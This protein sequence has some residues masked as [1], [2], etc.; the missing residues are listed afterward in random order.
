MDVEVPSELRQSGIYMQE[1]MLPNGFEWEQ[2]ARPSLIDVKQ[3]GIDS[4]PDWDIDIKVPEESKQS[5]LQP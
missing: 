3:L 1:V 5:I 2:N 4:Y